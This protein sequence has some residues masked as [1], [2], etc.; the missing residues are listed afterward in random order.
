MNHLLTKLL[1]SSCLLHCT[2][3]AMAQD[4]EAGSAQPS[5]RQL[6]V[7][8]V[9]ERVRPSLV[10]I[11]VN[12]RDG[13][14][15]GMGTG[16][17]VSSEGLIATNLHVIGE[18]RRFSVEMADG[19]KLEVKAVESSDR[20]QDLA[21]I[22]VAPTTEPL[23]PLPLGNVSQLKQGLP[24]VAMGN[25]WG[26]KE[27]VVSGVISAFR[28]IDGRELIQLAMPIEPGNSGGPVVDLQGRVL[29]VVNMKSTVEQN[30]AFALQVDALKTVLDKPN[31]VPIARWTAIGTMDSTEWSPLF[32]ARWRRRPGR[33]LVNGMGE[34]FGGRSLCLSN[35]ET[36]QPPFELAVAVK[37]D[38]ESGAAGLVFHSDGNNRHYGFYPSNGNLRLSCFR[39]PTVY[40]WQ[41]LREIES[42]HYR[43]GEWNHL[44]I[45]VETEKL[46]CFVNDQLVIESGDKTFTK[47]QVGLAKFRNTQAEFKQFQFAEHLPPSQASPTELERARK[48]LDEFPQLDSLT[49]TELDA[50]GDSTPAALTVLQERARALSQQAAGLEQQ[51]SQLR[52]LASDVHVYD[53]ARQLSALVEDPDEVDLLRG[54]LLIA[55]LEE[56]EVDVQAYVDSVERMAKEIR[57][58]LP[59]DAS[60]SARLAALNHYLFSESGYHGSRFDYYHRANSLM[61]RVIDDR[62]GLP[63]TLSVLYM[64]LGKRLGL[65]IQGVGLPGHFVVRYVPQ[66]GAGQLIDVFNGGQVLTRED[67][68]SLVDAFVNQELTDDH[69]RPAASR[70]ILTR[71]LRNLMNLAEKEQDKEAVLRCLEGLVALEPGSVQYRGLRAVVRSQT[72]RKASAIAD[73]DWIL[74]KQPPGLDLQRIR[75]MRE[76]FRQLP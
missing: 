4:S 68:A 32:G 9:V 39:G 25:P 47:G 59:K 64:Q 14:Q 41:V 75:E 74:E 8:Q 6:S 17:V 34:G 21:I 43:P 30:V 19:R 56:R 54:T 26:L 60:E 55:K 28:E 58:D 11:R 35:L 42:S 2:S 45:R 62:E 18:G 16:F 48:V 66:E 38:D 52:R 12:D 46:Q 37:L 71:T 69:L 44:K 50:L 51:A 1:I 70:E 57:D 23:V 67:A 7:E 22:R 49:A 76:Y 63:I 31:P 10:T 73:L 27:S 36:P 24:V 53:I 72:G 13:N 40:S 61:D 5:D 15:F 20:A 3:L 33:I 29:G 65:N